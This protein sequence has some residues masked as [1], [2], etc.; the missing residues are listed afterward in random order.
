M[1]RN[2]ERDWVHPWC[3]NITKSVYGINC[4]RCFPLQLNKKIRFIPCLIFHNCK[5]EKSGGS[6]GMVGGVYRNSYMRELPV[7]NTRLWSIARS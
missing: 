4:I 1:L 3:K 2:L 5:S 6:V 7:T